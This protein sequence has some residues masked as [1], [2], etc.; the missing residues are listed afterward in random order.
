M[1]E[2]RSVARLAVDSG[3]EEAPEV[4]ACL[5]LVS[6]VLSAA[7]TDEVE[8]ICQKYAL[9][10]MLYGSAELDVAELEA[11]VARGLPGIDSKRPE[12]A[13]VRR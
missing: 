13:T 9:E 12:P 10:S 7:W 1:S 8:D 6:E 3:L 4:R 11:A 2:R 5:D